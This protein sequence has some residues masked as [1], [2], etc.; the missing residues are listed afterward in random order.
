MAVTGASLI[1]E[2]ES[3]WEKWYAAAGETGAAILKKKHDLLKKWMLDSYG[4][5]SDKWRDAY[6]RRVS[7]INDIDWYYLED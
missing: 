3:T 6:L 1:C 2:P 4:V 7:E 5:D